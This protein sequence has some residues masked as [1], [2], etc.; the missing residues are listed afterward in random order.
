[1]R[2]LNA[3]ILGMS[4]TITRSSMY[5]DF[6][7]RGKSWDSNTG[8]LT[9]T[10]CRPNNIAIRM[11][12]PVMMTAAVW[13]LKSMYQFQFD[14]D[15]SYPPTI[16]AYLLKERASDIE[17]CCQ[18]LSTNSQWLLCQPTHTQFFQGNCSARMSPIT[19]VRALKCLQI[20][21]QA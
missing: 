21:D 10:E 3:A 9:S 14:C 12:W 17:S 5:N 4:A 13:S 15:A 1:M 18:K 6:D 19:H 2:R 7:I 11:N 16:L 8:N 20:F